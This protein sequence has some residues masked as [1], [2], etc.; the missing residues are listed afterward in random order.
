MLL[1]GW[2]RSRLRRDDVG[3]S[4]RSGDEVVRVRVDRDPVEA[5]VGDRVSG[6]DLLSNELD[7][8]GRDPVYEGAVRAAS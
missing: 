8:F 3:L 6:P 5:P 1:A 2:L 4:W 7:V